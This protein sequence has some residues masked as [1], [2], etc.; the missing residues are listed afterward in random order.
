MSRKTIAAASLAAALAACQPLIGDECETNIDC[1]EDG[2][3]FCDRT[4]PNG[5]CTIVD[6]E[7]NS[8][9]A[10][11]VCVEFFEGVHARSYCMRQCDKTSDCDRDLYVCVEPDPAI[12][13]ILDDP[14]GL[15][16]YCAPRSE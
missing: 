1:S 7:P 14:F 8:C 10:E 9:P 16:G 12:C 6:C 5:Y 13:T 15:K 11:G 2:D 3:R 4:Q